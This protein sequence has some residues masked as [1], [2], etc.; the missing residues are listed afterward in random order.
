MVILKQE[1]NMVDFEGNIEKL[2]PFMDKCELCPRKCKVD[3][4]NS[5]SLAT[6]KKYLLTI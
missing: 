4:N 1:C 2:Y 6:E 3:R 5:A